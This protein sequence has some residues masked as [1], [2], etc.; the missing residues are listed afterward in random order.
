MKP[1]FALAAAAVLLSVSAL[2]AGAL[3]PVDDSYTV[4][5]R[6]DTYKKDYPE[7]VWPKLTFVA[8]QR[9]LF[10]R[11]YKK[12]GER[13]L[14]IDI[15]LPSP[16]RVRHQAILFVHG[17]AWR[18]GNK[19]NFYALANLLA[20]RGYVVLLPEYRL[21]AEAEYPAGLIDINDAIVWA[22]TQAHD[23]GF[24]AG[25]L[26]IGGASS[27][28]QMAA[29]IAYSS[30]RDVFKSHA[31]LDTTVNALVDLDGLLDFTTPL[32]LHYENA[33][34]ANSPAALWFGG[35]YETQTSTWREASAA[36]H[37]SA[38]SPPTLI[39]SSGAPR[40]TAGR[41][42][43]ASVLKRYKI[44]Y[45]YFELEHAPH[46][47]WLF[48]PYLGQIVPKIDIFLRGC[49]TPGTEPKEKQ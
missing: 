11:L 40:F 2:R 16:K 9:I 33:A 30:D 25:K 19:S 24:A 43:A 46:T 29:L 27:G 18:S 39:V 1:F 37:L 41:E 35:A 28:G 26:A 12:I 47:F 32:A 17:G 3:I 4:S 21:S 8:G 15:F 10:D 38:A 31:G 7:I 49:G 42:D 6:Y 20:Q 48:D 44:R 34:G 23:L 22:K 14:H 36:T 13:E 5:Q 45:A